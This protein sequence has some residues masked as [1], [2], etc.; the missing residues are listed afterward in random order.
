MAAGQ[1][2]GKKKKKEKKERKNEKIV[3]RDL[4]TVWAKATGGTISTHHRQPG[5]CS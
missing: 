4:D 3:S 5:R 2:R 1:R